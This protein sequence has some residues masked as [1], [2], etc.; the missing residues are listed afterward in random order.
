MDAGLYIVGTPIGNLEDMSYRAVRTLSEVDLIL[1]EDTR[2]TGILL[3]RYEISKP[4]LSCHEFNERSRVERVMKEIEAGHAVALVS[5][6]GMPLISDPGSRL[7]EA[8]R[9]AGFFTTSIPGPTALTTAL[10]LSGWGQD[11]FIFL[12]FPPNKSAGRRR[13]LESLRDE[14]RTTVLYESTHRIN[15]LLADITEL[16]GDRPVFMARELTKKFE[17]LQQGTAAELA[18]F[19]ETHSS[20]GEFV[21]VLGPL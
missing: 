15:K 9:E 11:G 21:V 10:A 20:K 18:L 5:D 14:P 1:A 16:L 12:G 2:K 17:T 6:A 19:L 13:L 4:M 3:Q 7:V 8:V